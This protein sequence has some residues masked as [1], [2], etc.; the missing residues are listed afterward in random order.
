MK[1]GDAMSSDDLQRMERGLRITTWLWILGTMV[2]VIGIAVLAGGVVGG[3]DRIHLEQVLFTAWAIGP[4][5]WFILQ[6]YLWP[7]ASGGED[8]F[9]THQ[10]LVKA[11]WAGALALLA[12]TFF[13]RWG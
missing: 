6:N 12:A 7:P 2:T 5:A 8:R 11:V 1:E 9:R 13:G 4:P 3:R 10:A